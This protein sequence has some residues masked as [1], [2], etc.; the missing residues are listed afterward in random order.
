MLA[1]TTSTTQ[2]IL[3]CFGCFAIVSVV[4]YRE[5]VINNR[6]R[7]F[8]AMGRVSAA[9][10]YVETIG[11]MVAWTEQDVIMPNENGVMEI[12][13]AWSV[14]G[15]RVVVMY[16]PPAFLNPRAL[17]LLFLTV[18]TTEPDKRIT[19]ATCGPQESSSPDEFARSLLALL[20]H[21]GLGVTERAEIL[22]RDHFNPLPEEVADY[23][24][25]EATG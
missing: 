19:L 12:T 9:L 14:P 11:D 13:Y 10:A 5:N 8:K 4:L 7:G 20:K 3:I 1:V 23:V 2:S 21:H 18:V 15:A 24:T 6:Q 16:N 22:L 17:P 25:A